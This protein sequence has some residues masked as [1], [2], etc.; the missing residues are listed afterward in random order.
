MADRPPYNGTRRRLL[1][2]E[3]AALAK[4]ETDQREMAEVAALME[5]L[6]AEG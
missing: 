1:A 3:A 4:D 6:R 2:A 5:S